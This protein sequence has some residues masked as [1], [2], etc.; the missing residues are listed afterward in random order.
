MS[1]QMDL[2]ILRCVFWKKISLLPQEH[3]RVFH[4]SLG[5]SLSPF[6]LVNVYTL[7]RGQAKCLT[8]GSLKPGTVPE[9]H[10][11]I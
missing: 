4:S 11:G 7:M 5:Y 10:E 1:K 8:S 9:T 6:L 3:I 2:G